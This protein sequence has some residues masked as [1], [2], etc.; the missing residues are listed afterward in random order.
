M[1]TFVSAREFV[2]TYDPDSNAGPWE[3]VQQYY[4]AT[5]TSAELRGGTGG[6]A[7]SQRVATRLDLPRP[8]LRAWIDN[9]GK[10]D[11][12]RGLERANAKGWIEVNPSSTTFEGLNRL[13]AQIFAGGSITSDTSAPCFAI[14][15]GDVRTRITEACRYVGV[16]YRV[17]H[18]DDPDRATELRISGD[19]SILGRVLAVL[20]APVGEKAHDDDISLPNYLNEVSQFHRLDFARIYLFNRGAVHDDKA[21]LTISEDRPKAYR[22]EVAAFLEATLEQRV[23]SGDVTITLS[24]DAARAIQ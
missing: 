16:D 23:T 8:R 10:P 18:D 22:D 3:L 1:T 11:A 9:G 12:Q 15:S 7:G 20:G 21:T 5:K 14:P 6:R 4:H 24:A 19:G 17:V 2:E 13:V